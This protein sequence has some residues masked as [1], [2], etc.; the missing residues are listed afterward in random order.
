MIPLHPRLCSISP[1]PSSYGT[2]TRIWKSSPSTLGRAWENKSDCD[3]T[4]TRDEKVTHAAQRP[5]QVLSRAV[6]VRQDEKNWH[7][8]SVNTTGARAGGREETQNTHTN[9]FHLEEI[10]ENVPWMLHA[11]EIPRKIRLC[12][13]LKHDPCLHLWTPRY[14]MCRHRDTDTYRIKERE[15]EE[16]KKQTEF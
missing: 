9:E 16:P 8:D 1:R 12:H 6:Q 2:V 15:R 3:T 7:G 14:V 4:G 13:Y 5:R 10:E 11:K